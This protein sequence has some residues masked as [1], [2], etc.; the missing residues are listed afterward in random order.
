MRKG[1]IMS[2]PAVGNGRRTT[3]P[4]SLALAMGR[5]Q[6]LD[7][8]DGH[9]CLQWRQSVHHHGHR[10]GLPLHVRCS[11]RSQLGFER[12]AH[13]T[14]GRG[15]PSVNQSNSHIGIAGG[16]AP[17]KLYAHSFLGGRSGGDHRVG[18]LG[19][20]DARGMQVP[21]RR[22]RHGRHDPG[23][24]GHAET[25]RP[26]HVVA[27]RT[28]GTGRRATNPA[29]PRGLAV[30][31]RPLQG[32]PASVHL[33]G[34]PPVERCR[35]RGDGPR[36]HDERGGG[37]LALARGG[38][39]DLREQRRGRGVGSH[40]DAYL[41]ARHRRGGI[42]LR[43][44]VSDQRLGHVD[45]VEPWS[46]RRWAHRRPRSERVLRQR[47]R[48]AMCQRGSDV[49]RV[50]RQP[51]RDRLVD[52]LR[53]GH[54]AV[55]RA[56]P[57]CLRR[58]RH[59]H[60]ESRSH[61]HQPGRIVRRAAGNPGGVRRCQGPPNAPPPL[62]RRH[63]WD[64]VVRLRRRFVRDQRDRRRTPPQRADRVLRAHRGRHREDGARSGFE[65]HHR[66]GGSAPCQFG[67]V[68]APHPP[69]WTRP[70]GNSSW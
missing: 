54:R 30:H 69:W 52:S 58:G 41:Q 29:R 32:R 48:I 42:P 63:R 3:K 57:R 14:V 50:R 12:G 16:R 27:R 37:H 22:R 9:R 24:A 1:S 23:H 68:P 64:R 62:R 40:A 5:D 56:A 31:S 28:G 33:P 4:P 2:R 47:R 10:A 61:R 38:A 21:P 60:R 19:T 49:S 7:G 44:P 15:P 51:R 17:P 46:P 70:M 11:L 25:L 26:D 20:L 6:G 8:A 53:P 55:A 13:S 39:Q 34:R 18:G 36:Q 67:N 66:A 35:G 59:H 43:G 65:A 45:P